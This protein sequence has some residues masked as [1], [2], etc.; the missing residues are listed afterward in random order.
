MIEKANA[1]QKSAKPAAGAPE[2]TTNVKVNIRTD[3]GT[4]VVRLYDE[5]PLHRDNFISLVKKGFYDSLLFHRVIPEFMIQ[6]G[7]PGSKNAAP[8]A[9]LGS[10][11]G[12]M[13]R[14]PAEFRP[15]LFHKRGALAAARDGN[16]QKASSACQFYLVQ[17]KKL[18]DMDVQN[19]E[20]MGRVF[21]EEEKKIYKEQG[22]TPFLDQNYTVFGE[23]ESGMEVV[24][25]I[26][27]SPRNSQD[28]PDRDVRMYM[29]ILK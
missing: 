17:G 6:G 5:T 21:T 15:N 25:K 8:N 24:D 11:G 28:R 18:T 12:D 26:A 29:E 9:M 2:K 27:A 16:P 14:I 7:D 4:I 20:R 3:M 19:Y 10:G 1:Q 22:G 13:E 23:I